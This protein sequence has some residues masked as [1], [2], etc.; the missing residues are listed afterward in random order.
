MDVLVLRHM[1]RMWL[2]LAK[3]YDCGNIDDE[4]GRL[5]AGEAELES[6]DALH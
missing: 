5:I 4:L 1:G 3:Y 2:T 6:S